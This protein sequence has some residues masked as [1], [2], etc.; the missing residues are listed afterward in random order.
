MTTFLPPFPPPAAA[1][2]IRCPPALI[3]S[4]LL[5]CKRCVVDAE[6]VAVPVARTTQHCVPCLHERA[7]LRV[8]YRV[9]PYTRMLWSNGAFL[10]SN[11]QVIYMYL[12]RYCTY[13]FGIQDAELQC[14]YIAI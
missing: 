2:S 1:S 7:R 3:D 6:F 11:L 10:S 4:T 14:D 12:Y 8:S 9:Q 13:P 5:P